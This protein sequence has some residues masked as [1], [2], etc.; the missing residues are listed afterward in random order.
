MD[1]HLLSVAAKRLSSF[2]VVGVGLGYAALFT[3]YG[4]GIDQASNRVVAGCCAVGALAAWLV[5]SF[6]SALDLFAFVRRWVLRRRLRSLDQYVDGE[7]EALS[8]QVE[9]NQITKTERAR[10]VKR[11]FAYRRRTSFQ[12]ESQSRGFSLK[13]ME[14]LIKD[15]REPAAKPKAVRA[16]KAVPAPTPAETETGAE[17]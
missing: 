15:E 13:V 1:W 11:I 9:N 14:D 8:R 2:F 12:L 5:Y 17:G 4:W 7:L 6:V 3:A 16:K 10:E